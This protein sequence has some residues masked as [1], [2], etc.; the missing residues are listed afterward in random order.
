[1]HQGRAELTVV[2]VESPLAWEPWATAP[3]DAFPPAKT[4][5]N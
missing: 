5:A 2:L 4:K 1:M 3:F